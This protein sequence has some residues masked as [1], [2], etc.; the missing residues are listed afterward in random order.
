MT[1]SK[2]PR[3]I[4]RNAVVALLVGQ[5][6][7][8][9]A[10]RAS[11]KNPWRASDIPTGAILVYT[12]DDSIKED[13]TINAPV[14][15]ERT[16][17]LV[18][19]LAVEVKEDATTAADDAVDALARQIEI[20]LLNNDALGLDTNADAQAIGLIPSWCIPVGTATDLFEDGRMPIASASLK[21]RVKVYDQMLDANVTPLDDLKTIDVKYDLGDAQESDVVTEDNVTV[22]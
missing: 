3:T 20:L 15:Y 19:A 18:L 12:E 2:H 22:G 10:V 4:I 11:R 5:T 16:I 6:A 9:T 1:N 8:G 7:A 13:S 17:D 21:Y 14:R